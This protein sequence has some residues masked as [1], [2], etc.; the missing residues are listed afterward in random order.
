MTVQVAGERLSNEG[1]NLLRHTQK[2]SVN[3]DLNEGLNQGIPCEA[4]ME[5][6]QYI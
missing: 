6:Q 1:E 5:R 2:V 4:Q 3:A